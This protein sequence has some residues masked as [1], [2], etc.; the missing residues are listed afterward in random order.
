MTVL[1]QLK[2]V[3]FVCFIAQKQSFILHFIFVVDLNKFIQTIIMII[4]KR[5][6]TV[7]EGKKERKLN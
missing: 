1:D 6:N 3:I 5:N 4:E 2:R 7:F